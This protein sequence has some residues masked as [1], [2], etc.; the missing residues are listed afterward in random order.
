M[1]VGSWEDAAPVLGA[2]AGADTTA[3][4]AAVV[5]VALIWGMSPSEAAGSRTEST[6]YTV[7]LHTVK[8]P[9]KLAVLFGDS[10]LTIA[11]R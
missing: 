10:P 6:R 4:V 5:V 1:E 3:L 11:C 8:L 2:K 7:E 9:R